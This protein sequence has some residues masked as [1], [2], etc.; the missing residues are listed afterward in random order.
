MNS[1]FLRLRALGVGAGLLLTAASRVSAQGQVVTLAALEQQ[2]LASRQSVVALR[3]RLQRATADV[4]RRRLA[5]NPS[6]S[7][8]TDVSVS[9]GGQ[10][11][12]VAAADGDPAHDILV[13]GL[14]AVG[15][16]GAFAPQAR[17]GA[18]IGVSMSL[19]DS[20]RTSL[21]VAAARAEEEAAHAEGLAGRQQV[22]E[23]VRG[24][25]LTWLAATELV[26]ISEQA[27][28]DAR[29]RL[30]RVRDLVSEGMRPAADISPVA[31]DEAL[32]RLD[33]ARARAEVENARLMLDA[34]VGGGLP[35][36]ATPDRSALDVEA[37]PEAAASLQ[38]EDRAYAAAQA[39]ERQSAAARAT[40][41]LYERQRSPVIG[42]DAQVGLRAQNPLAGDGTSGLFPVFRIGVSVTVPL[43]DGG[44]A[45]ANAGAARA[46]A[47]E[48]AARSREL[49]HVGSTA[50]RGA[51]ADVAA[52]RE[53]LA[54]ARELRALSETRIRD[55]EDRY[56]L[57]GG[58]IEAIAEAYALRRRA[59]T[60]IVLAE[61]ATAR[62]L[63]RLMGQ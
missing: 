21:A 24:A 23:E 17:Y 42:A 36:S 37:L 5:D 39:L 56:E 57:A 3:A 22:L 2:A 7:L 11:E 27:V 62:A 44:S 13:Q 51:G 43:W 18:T 60:E 63:Y 30:Q 10:L 9:P 6:I 28:G 14:R 45:A 40:A 46:Q 32:V 19:Y 8:G 34:A 16:Q 52:A 38:V 49:A 25:Y 54:I 20:G 1:T 58:R 47:A 15:D 53:R 26:A 33:A 4:E 61:V 31:S 50:R 35:P 55:A 59:S 29:A 48:L 12:R 41:D